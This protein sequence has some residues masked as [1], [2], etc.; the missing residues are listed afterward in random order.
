MAQD[1]LADG[2]RIARRLGAWICFA[3]EAGQ[4][5][6]PARARTWAPRGHT[7][8]VRVTG[9]GSGRISIAALACYK[10]EQ[11]S[12]LIYRMMTHRGRKGEKKGFREHD[13]AELLD[14][15]HQQLGGPIVLVWDNL[16]GHTSALM[17]RLVATRTWL[18]VYQLPSYAPELNPVESVWSH[19]KRSLANLAAGTIIHM[20]VLARTRL[21]RM[22]YLPGLVDAF[23]TGTGLRP[24]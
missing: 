4:T 8:V 20:A 17:R 2:K 16:G 10:P 7:P 11:R 24:P 14:A 1:H 5:L 6:R 22:Q 12:R 3:D 15:A 9:K 19:L 18:R 21:K 23:L 13:F